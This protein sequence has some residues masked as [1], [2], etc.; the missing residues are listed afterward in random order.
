M[1]CRRLQALG[2]LAAV[3]DFI[4]ELSPGHGTDAGWVSGARRRSCFT[5]T[6]A[7]QG[8]GRTVSSI[9]SGMTEMYAFGH[10][11]GRH[12]LVQIRLLHSRKCHVKYNPKTS[13]LAANKARLNIEIEAHYKAKFVSLVP[14]HFRG[15]R[16]DEEI[17][18]SCP[19]TL[20]AASVAV[21]NLVLGKIVG[22]RA[23]LTTWPQCF[24]RKARQD[25]TTDCWTVRKKRYLQARS[26]H[27]VAVMGARLMYRRISRCLELIGAGESF[28]R[29]THD[30][31]ADYHKP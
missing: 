29:F 30:V 31:F 1:L 20:N 15:L 13:T 7:R 9:P 4:P 27:Q 18:K 26:D 10:S 11:H 14:L 24:Q 12:R 17:R 5:F 16:D 22:R 2:S 3:G 8:W 19:V 6:R 23:L 21:T 25:C 28:D